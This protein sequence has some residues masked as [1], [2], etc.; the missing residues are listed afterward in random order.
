MALTVQQATAGVLVDGAGVRM[1][2]TVLRVRADCLL[3]GEGHICQ[4]HL[5][6]QTEHELNQQQRCN[7][8]V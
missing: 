4:R 8:P 6:L 5:P 7:H 2:W 1:S 3:F